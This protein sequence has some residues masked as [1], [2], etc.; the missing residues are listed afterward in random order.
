MDFF[1][2]WVALASRPVEAGISHT[3]SSVLQCTT[4]CAGPLTLQ[5]RPVTSFFPSCPRHLQIPVLNSL[6]NSTPPLQ[7]STQQVSRHVGRGMLMFANPLRSCTI[8]CNKAL[9]V[10]EPTFSAPSCV[11][12]FLASIAKGDI[13]KHSSR[14]QSIRKLWVL[15]KLWHAL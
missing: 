12:E 15:C 4:A 6:L 14:R 13:G 10:V 7:N 9:S 3:G 2:A 8:T 11:H 1:L 5:R